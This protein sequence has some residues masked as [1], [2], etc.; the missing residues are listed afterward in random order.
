[1]SLYITVVLKLL[2]MVS[3]YFIIRY[4]VLLVNNVFIIVLYVVFAIY[5]YIYAYNIYVYIYNIYIFVCICV[6][7]YVYVKDIEDMLPV[8]EKDGVTPIRPR[9]RFMQVGHIIIV[10]NVIITI[11]VIN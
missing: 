6:C 10:I 7:I 4:H 3:S 9:T 5:T 8:S 1:M 11:T 2:K